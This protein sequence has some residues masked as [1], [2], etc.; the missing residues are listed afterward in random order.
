MKAA[1]RRAASNGIDQY[2]RLLR[3]FAPRKHAS[4]RRVVVLAPS[5]KGSLGDEAVIKASTDHLTSVLGYEVDLLT[6]DQGL[7]YPEAEAISGYV[8]IPDY[9]RH[10][11]WRE[12]IKLANRLRNYEQFFLLGTDS[13]DGGYSEWQSL[14]LLTLAEQAAT[15]GMP[16]SVVGFSVREEPKPSCTEALQRVAAHER[17]RLCIRDL[18]S[19]DRLDGMVRRLAVTA[20]PAF[21]LRPD[22]AGDAAAEVLRWIDAQRASGHFII[23][24]NL[25]AHVIEC[26]GSDAA[27][28]LQGSILEAL[29]AAGRSIGKPVAVILVPHDLRRRYDDVAFCESLL[30]EISGSGEIPAIV[31][32]P[33]LTAAAAKAV[34]G[35]TDFVFSGRMHLAIAALGMCVPVAC[36]SYQGKFEG[37]YQHFGLEPLTISPADAC[38]AGKLSRFLT[39]AILDCARLK[40]SIEAALPGVTE[41]AR[42]NFG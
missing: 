7:A 19:K 40:S 37:L 26:V 35:H 15:S 23:G 2:S 25:S 32:R 17:A 27:P 22:S 20:D 5:W 13:L 6:F 3:H 11:G 30:P 1:L 42:A 12:R 34:I 18:V 9:F 41:L 21:L 16:T 36:I 8:N 24:L 33:P 29:A 31:F 38:D 28:R 39:G 14:G 10:G 4:T